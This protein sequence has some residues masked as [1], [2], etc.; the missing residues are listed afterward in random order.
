[1]EQNEDRY[2]YPW[3]RN[4]FFVVLYVALLIFLW[5]FP[6]EGPQIFLRNL[7]RGFLYLLA[8]LVVLGATA[9]VVLA[10]LPPAEE[11][12]VSNSD[13]EPFMDGEMLMLSGYA[14]GVPVLTDSARA[15]DVW[16]ALE[17]FQAQTEEPSTLII[18]E[19][20]GVL[21]LA[22]DEPWLADDLLHELSRH[23]KD[24][25]IKVKRVRS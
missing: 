17:R 4:L 22:A 5:H 25:G 19:R 8:G 10:I 6:L 9:L 18:D 24:A 16:L 20:T 3:L 12:L 15:E 13:F 14:L 1:M 23:L 2:R 21:M 11:E 7:M